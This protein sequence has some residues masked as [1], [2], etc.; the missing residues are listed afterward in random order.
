MNRLSSTAW[1]KTRW[2]VLMRDE[3]TCQSCGRV[4]PATGLEA[5][6]ITPREILS[7]ERWYDKDQCQTLCVEC[8][9]LKTRKEHP[10]FDPQRYEFR[11]LLKC[12]LGG[13]A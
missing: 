8:H 3:F 6:H 5:D 7:Q 11:Q 12:L 13:P 1:S 4:R 10:Y 9:G 2:A